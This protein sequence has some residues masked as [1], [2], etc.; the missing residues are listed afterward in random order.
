MFDTLRDPIRA[1]SSKSEIFVTQPNPTRAMDASDPCPR[2]NPFL[3][4]GPK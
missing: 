2:I 4:I 3:P 1:D